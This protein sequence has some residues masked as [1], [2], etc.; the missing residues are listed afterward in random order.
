MRREIQDILCGTHVLLALRIAG[1][2]SGV[3]VIVRTHDNFP[4]VALYF[5]CICL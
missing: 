5:I 2:L 1:K 3:R 4:V